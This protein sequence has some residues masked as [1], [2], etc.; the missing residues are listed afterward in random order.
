MDYF[1]AFAKVKYK[2]FIVPNLVKRAALTD[3]EIIFNN[4]YVLYPYTV[5]DDERPEDVAYFYYGD[6]EMVWLVYYANKIVDP[7]YEWPLNN[8]NLNKKI[9]SEYKH[10]TLETDILAWSMNTT[11]ND[12]ILY[13]ISDNGI[14]INP[15]TYS[16]I[17]NQNDY[18]PVRIYE[19]EF[20]Q[21]EKKRN[22]LLINKI[23]A[24][25]AETELRD[26]LGR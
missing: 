4:P 18:R 16:N 1:D 12:N 5:K 20:E 17:S 2:G 15:L 7:Y 9:I 24:N 22:I 19:Y 25:Q 21:N 23:Y 11:I 8:E 6:P 14:K 10:K 3:S 26:I 13:Y